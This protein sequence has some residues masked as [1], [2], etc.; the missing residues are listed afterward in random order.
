LLVGR[1]GGLSSLGPLGYLVQNA[2]D[3]RTAIDTLISHMDVH[4]RGAAPTLELR[5]HV[6]M[7]RYDILSTPTPRAPF[8]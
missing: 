5:A 8:P 6:A 4:D 7:L 3:V 2:P 1:A